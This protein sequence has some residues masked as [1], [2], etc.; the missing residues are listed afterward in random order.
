MSA[1]KKPNRRYRAIFFDLVGTLMS[2]ASDD[3]AHNFFMDVIVDKYRVTTEPP[4][5]L[6]EFDARVR[7][8]YDIQVE[9]WT[10]HRETV[11]RAVAGIL[12]DHGIELS[13]KDA[14]WLY[15]E[16]LKKHQT[17]VRLLAGAREVLDEAKKLGVHIGLIANLDTE[18][19]KLQ[20][21]W[22]DIADAFTSITTAEEV[23]A[24]KPSPRIYKAALEKAGCEPKAAIM[25]GDS[26]ERDI[27]GAKALG[28]TT[29]LLDT[30]MVKDELSRADF[31]ASDVPR[32][33]K[34]LIELVY[35]P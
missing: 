25:V 22:L 31:V 3:E 32:V 8:P 7:A 15:Q 19:V 26:V 2:A 29:V 16:Y 10:S 1:P 27:A 21:K 4:L 6:R 5:L 18:Y 35:G 28:I 9:S 33:A 30:R 24:R 12:M 23:G 14:E 17:Y 11:K 13:D 34:I 20:L